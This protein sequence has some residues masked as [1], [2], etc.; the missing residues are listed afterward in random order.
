[1]R[2]RLAFADG[3]PWCLAA[4]SLAALPG[5]LW[6]SGTIAALAVVIVA[7]LPLR[8]CAPPVVL[9]LVGALI[10]GF[11]VGGARLHVLAVDPF[12][13]DRAVVGVPVLVEEAW[14]GHGTTRV[15]FAR[16]LDRPRGRVLL[17]VQTRPLPPRG[18]LIVVDGRLRR[19]EGERGG[20]DER[21][22]LLRNGAHRVLVARHVE[23][24]G[25]RGGW[26]G[27]ADRLRVAALA[28]LEAFGGDP[29]AVVAGLTYG[30]QGGISS[31]AIDDFRRS[32]LAHLLAVSGGNVALLVGLVVLV[33]WAMG[34]SRRLAIGSAIAVIA[35][36]VAIVG[37][38]PSVVRAGVAGTA[39]CVAWLT[40]RPR[41]AWRALAL[42]FAVLVVANPWT[43]FDPGFQL[44]FVAVAAI[45]VVIG[46]PRVRGI[47]T[48]APRAV[49][50]VLAV[51]VA[52]TIATAP[53][54]WWHFGRAS[55]LGALPANAL[56]APA[57]PLVLWLA[58]LA[59][60][61]HPV[62]PAAA[63][64][65]A[66]IAQGPAWWVL[67]CAELGAG[68]DRMVPAR[69]GLAALAA[70]ALIPLRGARSRIR[71]WPRR[72][73]PSRPPTSSGERIGTRCD[74][75]SSACAGASPRMPSRSWRPM[76]ANPTRSWPP[77][78][79]RG[80]SRPSGSSSSSRPTA[81]SDRSAPGDSIP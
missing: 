41:Q 64:G 40:S 23:V 68:I 26:E 38:E 24:V 29:A 10:A 72:N 27:I 61:L 62:A 16:T 71:A 20:F 75:P 31:A 6:A 19:P 54:A 63:L 48:V 50:A 43:V 45:L 47:A 76:P 39:A 44:S 58:L 55:L 56:A 17:R 35:L 60:V 42:G 2:R 22:W 3:L 80:S 36:Y 4:G 8:R 53:I 57:V 73:E 69:L 28:P 59:S 77:A 14:R 15:A 79:S 30:A 13:G 81:G 21:A 74:A 49:V 37:P 25:M 1:M 67:R 33:V 18:A 9:A 5:G 46:H 66:W 11:L 12:G 51:T 7:L 34:A 70:V 65:L 78:A 52:A 32:G